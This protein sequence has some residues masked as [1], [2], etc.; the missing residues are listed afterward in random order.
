MIDKIEIRNFK[1]I[2]KVE[3][4]LGRLNVLI[5]SNGSGKSN[6]LEAVGF[7]S[8]AAADKLDNEF[9]GSRGIRS[10]D[11]SLMKNAFAND[12]SKEPIVVSFKVGKKLLTYTLEADEKPVLKWHIREKR[13]LEEFTL[14]AFTSLFSGDADRFAKGQEIKESDV[15]KF[16]EISAAVKILLSE[17]DRKEL[18]EYM[19]EVFGDNLINSMY[20]Q[21]LYNK[22]IA[23]FLI[24]SPEIGALRK[25][26]QESQIRPIGIHGEG[27]FN[28]LQIFY[29]NKTT[30]IEE[31][32][33]FLHMIDWFDD[34]NPVSDKVSGRRSLVV[35]D[36]FMNNTTLNQT[37]V[38]EGFLFLMFY[39]LLFMSKETP[40]FYSIDNIETSFHPL[41]CKELARNLSS[42]AIKHKKQAIIT[43]HNPFVLDGLDLENSQQRL[44]VVRRNS[45]GETIVDPIKEKPKGIKLSEAWMTGMLGGIPETF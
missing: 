13:Q 26:E 31:L 32:K 7:G 18:I 21:Q 35:K 4:D 30:T 19:R 8:A 43:T 11:M 9:L 15:I 28:L 29:E 22:E 23:E 16:Q 20:K 33:S 27:L 2:R 24:Y 5:G 45:D 42:L 36:R 12:P 25:L 3:L 39:V 17:N 10:S 14:N 40:D 1:S 34:F 41:L 38:N 37:N 6:I 44:F